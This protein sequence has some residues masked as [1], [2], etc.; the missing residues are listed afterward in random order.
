MKRIMC[1]L[2]MLAG[3]SGLF[4]QPKVTLFENING[5][6]PSKILRR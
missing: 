5:R 4:S 6:L 3:V 2:L 1:A